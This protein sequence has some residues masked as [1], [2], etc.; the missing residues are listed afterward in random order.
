MCVKVDKM[1]F[2]SKS[3]GVQTISQSETVQMYLETPFLTSK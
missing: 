2:H 1:A 3:S